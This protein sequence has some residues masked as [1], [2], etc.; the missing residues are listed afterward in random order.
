MVRKIN[1]SKNPHHQC[2][3]LG[4]QRIEPGSR[5]LHLIAKRYTPRTIKARHSYHQ[6]K[7]LGAWQ[8]GQKK[9]DPSSHQYNTHGTRHT[10][11]TPHHQ[12]KTL[13][14]QQNPAPSMQDIRSSDRPPV[15]PRNRQCNTL[16]AWQQGKPPAINTRHMADARRD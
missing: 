5:Q 11:K 3:T 4:A 13:G 2:K 6:C 7:T 10:K 16:G 15:D 14:A 1:Q 12:C 8:Q 9:G